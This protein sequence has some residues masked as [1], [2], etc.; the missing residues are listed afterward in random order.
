MN[1]W[2]AIG[3]GILVFYQVTFQASDNYLILPEYLIFNNNFGGY[4]FNNI[5][6]F[7]GFRQLYD[8]FNDN[9]SIS[10]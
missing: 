9:F 1:Y 7:F 4:F 2:I 10:T 5:Y 8:S 6:I 3:Y